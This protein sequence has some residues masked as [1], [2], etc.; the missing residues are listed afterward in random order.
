MTKKHIVSIVGVFALLSGNVVRSNA[1]CNA[2]EWQCPG[3]T[4]LEGCIDAKAVCDGYGIEDCV[5]NG[6]DEAPDYCKSFCD[7]GEA[8]ADYPLAWKEDS[9]KKDHFCSNFGSGGDTPTAITTATATTTTTTTSASGS[10]LQPGM[11][12]AAE[13]LRTTC[14]ND[15]SGGTQLGLLPACFNAFKPFV[16]SAAFPECS[17][18][19]F[20]GASATCTSCKTS[21]LSTL[22]S[23]S[24]SG[25]SSGPSVCNVHLEDFAEDCII[26]NTWS[27]RRKKELECVG[28]LN[29]VLPNLQDSNDYPECAAC[30]PAL[31]PLEAGSFCAECVK[32]IYDE[33]SKCPFCI[34]RCY[35]DLD[36]PSECAQVATCSQE[37]CSDEWKEEIANFVSQGCKPET[38]AGDTTTSTTLTDGSTRDTTPTT[39][40]STTT[41]TATTRTT[42]GTTT[43]P[44][45]TSTTTTQTA[46]TTTTTT[47]KGFKVTNGTAC[48]YGYRMP[49]TQDECKNAMLETRGAEMKRCFRSFSDQSAGFPEWW[50]Q[51]TLFPTCFAREP[52]HCFVD[53]LKETTTSTSTSTSTSTTRCSCPEPSSGSTTTTVATTSTA[54]DTTDTTTTAITTTKAYASAAIAKVFGRMTCATLY[55]SNLLNTKIQ[56]D[57]YAEQ[58]SVAAELVE[59]IGNS[60]S[61]FFFTP[62]SGPDP[63]YSNNCPKDVQTL[64]TLLGNQGVE[65]Y[66]D[67]K[68]V[69]LRDCTTHLQKIQSWSDLE[70]FCV[71]DPSRDTT[72]TRTSTTDTTSTTSVTITSTTATSTSATMSTTT[73]ATTTSTTRTS[74]TDTSTTS[75]VTTPILPNNG[76]TLTCVPF[77]ATQEIECTVHIVQLSEGD[78]RFFKLEVVGDWGKVASD[79]R[80]RTESGF[81]TTD[82]SGRWKGK[83][84]PIVGF[85]HQRI[86][87]YAYS[88]PSSKS[89]WEA[90]SF[91]AFVSVP[92]ATTV[93][94]TTS[95][96]TTLTQER[97]CEDAP[98][99][100]PDELQLHGGRMECSGDSLLFCATSGYQEFAVACRAAC[101]LCTPTVTTMTATTVTSGS[102]STS[103]TPT[104]SSSSASASIRP[105]SEPVNGTACRCNPDQTFG[106]C[107]DD[108][109][110]SCNPLS[111]SNVCSIT[112]SHCNSETI[113]FCVASR[114]GSPG[115][116]VGRG[117]DCLARDQS[118]GSPNRLTNL[119]ASFR[120]FTYPAE[121]RTRWCVA[122]GA[123]RGSSSFIIP[124][125]ED[126][127][128]PCASAGGRPW[129]PSIETIYLPNSQPSDASQGHQ[130]PVCIWT[131]GGSHS[132]LQFRNDSVGGCS[133]LTAPAER[134]HGAPWIPAVGNQTT[135]AMSP[136]S[137]G[138][139][140][141]FAAPF[142][143]GVCNNVNECSTSLAQCH[144]DAG[145]FDVVGS[146][147][148]VCNPGYVGDGLSCE[149]AKEC[150]DPDVHQCGETAHCIE[151]TGSYECECNDG[152][153][154]NGTDCV[155]SCLK[156]GCSSSTNNPYAHGTFAECAATSDDALP[157][158]CQC[159]P[160]F[161]TPYSGGECRDVDECNAAY[162]GDDTCDANA[163]CRNLFGGHACECKEGYQG[164][165]YTCTS[166]CVFSIGDCSDDASCSPV[167]GCTCREGFAGDGSVCEDINECI[168]TYT[169]CDF[170]GHATCTNTKGSFECACNDGWTGPGTVCADVKECHVDGGGCF[171]HSTCIETEGSFECS[172][173]AGWVLSD[174]KD[175]HCIDVDECQ[176]AASGGDDA[177]NANAMCYNVAGSFECECQAG[178]HNTSGY[179]IDVDECQIAASGGDDACDA[180]AMCGNMGVW[181]LAPGAL[182]A[183][184][185]IGGVAMIFRRKSTKS[186]NDVDPAI[187]IPMDVMTVVPNT[188]TEARALASTHENVD[189]RYLAVPTEGEAAVQMVSLNRYSVSSSEL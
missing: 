180:N 57:V 140:M 91:P 162:G 15:L 73:T 174:S 175:G 22:N 107:R 146:Y 77:N 142:E 160:G 45:T 71:R 41:S 120:A 157:F 6:A 81:K 124:A 136:C 27:L 106:P 63:L 153:I 98:Y 65:F 36:L 55:N 158:A 156:Y 131:A 28:K 16:T 49:A 130:M 138:F 109:T 182:G 69:M 13:M 97:A 78:F 67:G 85:A 104:T 74:M 46:S 152:F 39:T 141:E 48:G 23:C 10:I 188:A 52:T 169:P 53:K 185:L 126:D 135:F 66:C 51:G 32:Q 50:D 166:N 42:T 155:P 114:Y 111:A 129:L 128:V 31:Q 101:N 121:G 149:D 189:Y 95:R 58:E 9:S 147:F 137:S 103:S 62:A 151:R 60:A 19:C 148:C 173:N 54:T 20:G 115:H 84:V 172:C 61:F 117:G 29:T 161:E 43:T 116:F 133:N 89:S 183:L 186:S 177:C 184:I 1:Q 75:T 179:C 2:G 59:S 24:R 113:L 90:F 37:M 119:V 14:Q 12:M 170:D 171:D 72:S 44:S 165:G 4:G 94:S 68:A 150:D 56:N 92:W 33:L 145:C 102:T 30:I 110:A 83:V 34:L 167:A 159:R 88:V 187:S 3:T 96:T 144:T 8:F 21:L 125:N 87:A 176:I 38:D 127:S 122:V 79:A 18:G 40:S 112:H 82:R 7:K 143:P 11:C 154:S 80:P 134:A 99:N 64:N 181:L 178:Y 5:E 105:T 86:V 100:I 25:P 35:S 139:D 118:L 123:Q 47:L 70:I 108:A 163:I 76:M 168:E 164:D 26:T 93:V 132:L 17:D